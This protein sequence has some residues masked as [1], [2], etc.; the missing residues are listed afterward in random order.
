MN[1]RLICRN[2]IR[3][4]KRL[5]YERRRG[6]DRIDEDS[7]QFMGR[8]FWIAEIYIVEKL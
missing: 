6:V 5:G 7:K 8:A 2:S 1:R 4:G 3:E